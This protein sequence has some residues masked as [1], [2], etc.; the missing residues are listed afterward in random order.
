MIRRTGDALHLLAAALLCGAA[1]CAP[2][3][4][5]VAAPAAAPPAP[6][7]PADPTPAVAPAHPADERRLRLAVLEALRPSLRINQWREDCDLVGGVW[8]EKPSPISGVFSIHVCAG[9]R[10]WELP[11][12][13]V[14]RGE[15]PEHTFTVDAESLPGFLDAV[16]NDPR[17]S[18]VLRPTA[19][20]VAAGHWTQEV[21]YPQVVVAWEWY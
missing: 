3:R 4:A 2:R 18:V 6:T 13:S 14:V 16:R 17:V 15:P 1:G 5:L 9:G 12:L 20:T 10:K 19:A 21:W 8:A 11:R 7:R